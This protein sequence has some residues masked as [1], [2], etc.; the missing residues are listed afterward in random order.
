MPLGNQSRRKD[1]L[2]PFK[3]FYSLGPDMVG[4]PR[5]HRWRLGLPA[6]GRAAAVG[7]FRLRER[8]AQAGM[9]Q[10]EIIVDMM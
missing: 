6:L 8:L 5:G 3:I 9:G 1:I 10:T 4:Q 7:G 2:Q